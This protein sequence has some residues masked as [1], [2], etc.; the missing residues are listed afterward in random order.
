MLTMTTGM[1]K[2]DWGLENFSGDRLRS[3][4]RPISTTYLLLRK[5]F[6]TRN[7][8]INSG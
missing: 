2:Q 1:M 4:L 6:I 5:W 3:Q 7:R 8:W